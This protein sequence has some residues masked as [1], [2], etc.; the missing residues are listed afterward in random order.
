MRVGKVLGI[1][2]FATLFAMFS[3]REVKAFTIPEG[4][5]FNNNKKEK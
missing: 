4:L 1:A 5:S 3:F 2:V